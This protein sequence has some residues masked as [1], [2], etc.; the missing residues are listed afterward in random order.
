MK[1][2]TK[3][4]RPYIPFTTSFALGTIQ[5][6]ISKNQRQYLALEL[7]DRTGRIRGLI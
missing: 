3:D 1:L 6:R 5:M 4:I 2:M 7:Y